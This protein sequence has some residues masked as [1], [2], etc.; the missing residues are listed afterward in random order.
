MA[1]A[2]LLV[3]AADG[4]SP[5]Y[6][7]YGTMGGIQDYDAEGARRLMTLDVS[8]SKILTVVGPVTVMSKYLV[9]AFGGQGLQVP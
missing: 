3:G 8:G 2:F 6:G 5:G 7:T 4:N 1:R 9:I